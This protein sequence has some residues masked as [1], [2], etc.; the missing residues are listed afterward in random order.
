MQSPT[1]S[2]FV[3][4]SLR[5]IRSL[6]LYSLNLKLIQIGFAL[7]EDAI[8]SSNCAIVDRRA[9]IKDVDEKTSDLSKYRNEI[10]E[11]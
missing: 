7:L 8:E 1:S 9:R 11:D 3:E 4:P 6:H 10:L 2:H 5:V